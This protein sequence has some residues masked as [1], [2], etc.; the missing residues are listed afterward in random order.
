MAF[1]GVTPV[2]VI[3]FQRIEMQLEDME[4]SPAEALELIEKSSAPDYVK[5]KFVERLHLDI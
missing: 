3:E 2:W 5:L 4:I 1:S